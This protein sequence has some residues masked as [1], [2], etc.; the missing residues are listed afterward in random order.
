MLD[1]HQAQLH[2]ELLQG[3]GQVD[4]DDLELCY[5]PPRR[6]FFFFLEF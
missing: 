6:F 2:Q 5:K 3:Q 1:M 4:D